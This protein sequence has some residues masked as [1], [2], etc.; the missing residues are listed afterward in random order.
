MV[1]NVKNTGTRDGLEIVQLYASDEAPKV[2]K[3]S[4]EL[5]AF[6]KVFVAAGQEKEVKLK[7]KVS[8]LAYFDEKLM[9]WV[10]TPGSYKL[11]AG[12]SSQTILASTSIVVE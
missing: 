3:A 9:K 8:D 7:I 11:M 2:F 4:K 5:K 12:T 6:A 1:V 10:V